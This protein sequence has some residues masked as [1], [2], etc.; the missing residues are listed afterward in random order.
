MSLGNVIFSF[1]A[2]VVWA[3]TL[4]GDWDEFWASQPICHKII[5]ESMFQVAYEKTWTLEIKKK[6]R[7]ELES[8][9]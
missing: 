6:K 8:L 3:E 4:E 1:S 9:L 7:L 2:S 5:S